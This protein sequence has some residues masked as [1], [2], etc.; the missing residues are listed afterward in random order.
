M[1]EFWGWGRKVVHIIG[2]F[3]VMTAAGYAPAGSLS[4]LGEDAMRQRQVID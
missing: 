1:Q 3:N 4:M 2:Q